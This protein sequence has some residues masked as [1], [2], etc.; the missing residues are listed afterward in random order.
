MIDEKN[1]SRPQAPSQSLFYS[2]GNDFAVHSQSPLG[3][4]FEI[5]NLASSYFSGSPLAIYIIPIFQNF[6]AILIEITP[7]E[8][9]TTRSF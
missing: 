1:G 6:V 9:Y 4:I 7:D 8:C 5:M 3:G 2:S